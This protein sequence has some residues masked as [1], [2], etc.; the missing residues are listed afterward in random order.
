M[1]IDD[2]LPQKQKYRMLETP[3]ETLID[4]RASARASRQTAV[5]FT[6]T[7]DVKIRRQEELH[8]RLHA[9]TK[10]RRARNTDVSSRAVTRLTSTVVSTITGV[11]PASFTICE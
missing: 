10:L 2:P 8:A 3:V 7:Y 9:V 5:D 4:L 6:R 11:P 1:I